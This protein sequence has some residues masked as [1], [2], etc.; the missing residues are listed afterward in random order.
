MAGTAPYLKAKFQIGSVQGRVDYERGEHVFH[1][2][3]VPASA[4][5]ARLQ[6]AG[7]VKSTKLVKNFPPWNRSTLPGTYRSGMR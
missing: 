3:D 6:V 2:D 1:K 7:F 4:K 5:Q